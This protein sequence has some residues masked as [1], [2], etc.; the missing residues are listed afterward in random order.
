MNLDDWDCA[1]GRSDAKEQ[2]RMEST[3]DSWIDIQRGN[4][5]YF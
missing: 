2:V 1:G 5:I 3:H 4:I